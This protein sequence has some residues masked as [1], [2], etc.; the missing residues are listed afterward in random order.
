MKTIRAA[1]FESNSS[2]SHSLTVGGKA[3]NVTRKDYKG[4]PYVLA[5][6]EYGWGYDELSTPDEKI[7]YLAVEAWQR[8]N[9]TQKDWITEILQDKFN[10][11]EVQFEEGSA[12]SSYIDHQ[13]QGRIWSEIQTK[14]DLC[15]VVFGSSTITIDND[16]N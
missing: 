7:N 5:G 11:G 3:L 2:S 13:S 14:A 8:D 6:G 9:Q 1:I 4:T 10:C 16:N 15:D 12:E